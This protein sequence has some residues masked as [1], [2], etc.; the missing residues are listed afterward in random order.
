MDL[1]EMFGV[2]TEPAPKKEEK[3]KPVKK[4]KKS[5]KNVTSSKE[6]FDCPMSVITD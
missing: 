4:E 6:T 3:K 1:F 2:C 5:S